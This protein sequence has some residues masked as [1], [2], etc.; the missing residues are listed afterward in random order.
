MNSLYSLSVVA[1]MMRTSPRASTDL[2]TLAASD[3]APSAE[4]APIIVC[5]SSMNRI[6]FG[7]SLISRITFWMRSSNM[8]RS[9][10]PGDHRVHLQVDDLAV[11]QADRH[12]LR[13]ELDAARQPFG[14]R[15]LAD[16][17]LAEQQHRVGA[18]AVAEDLEHLLHLGVA[19]EDRRNLV[20]A[21]ELVQVGGEVLEERRQLEALLQ[22]LLAQLVVAHPR[23]EPR[24]ERFRLDA[25]AADDRDRDALR[26][27]EDRR[28]QVGRFDGVPAGAAGVQQ[29]ELEQQLGRRRDAQVAAGHARQQPQ[30]LFERLQDLV[31]VQLEIA[32][33]LAEHVP[34]DLRERQADVLVGQER[35]FAAAG[36]VERA[37]D[38]ALG[39]LGQLVLRDVEVFHGRLHAARPALAGPVLLPGDQQRERRQSVRGRSVP[40]GLGWNAPGNE[41]GGSNGHGD[42]VA[43][44]RA[45]RRCPVTQVVTRTCFSGLP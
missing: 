7:R 26:L 4:P 24:H 35:V 32:H 27:L 18:L 13:L 45:T 19:A 25:V 17:R 10:V 5:T 28:E 44:R 3:G 39:R 22:P 15:R 9:I 33:D 41:Q 20:L 1:P 37:V 40:Q 14:D 30:V 34:F 31:R 36:F 23:G 11:A 21:R 16:A 2:K 42:R 38:D 8:P 12:L 29:R 43:A 6:R